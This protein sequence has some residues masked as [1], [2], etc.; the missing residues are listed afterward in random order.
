MKLALVSLCDS[1][2]VAPMGL[3]YIAGYLREYMDRLDIRI[4]DAAYEDPMAALECYQPDIVGVSA[5]T[6]QYSEAM[7]FCRE[8]K[9][10]MSVPIVLGGVHVST[11]PKSFTQEFD[12]GVI[13]EGEETMCELLRSFEQCGG[14]SKEALRSIPGLIFHE[15]GTLVR[16][17]PR[18]P[19]NPLDEIPMPDQSLLH[20]NYFI[21][22]REAIFPGKKLRYGRSLTIRGC[23]FQCS[24]C[25][26]TVFWNKVRFHSAERIALEVK[27]LVEDY[28]V[29]MIPIV[30]DLF[31]QSRKRLLQIVEELRKHGLLG[32]VK[33]AV[34]YRA[35]CIKD[36]LCEIL[37]EMGVV[38]VF[39][40]FESGNDRVLQSLKLGSINVAD[41]KRAILL[42]KK[43]GFIVHGSLMLGS[44]G[45]TIADMRDTLAFMDWMAQVDVDHIWFFVTTPFPETSFWEHCRK[46]NI[47]SDNMD[48]DI[49][50]MENI[51]K[52]LCLDDTVPMEEFRALLLD[53]EKKRKTL[54]PTPPIIERL[55][56]F[57]K[58]LKRVLLDPRRTIR[59]MAMR[60]IMR[61][62]AF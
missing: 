33:F 49:L 7:K 8:L 36:E 24:F 37:K 34:Q 31:T 20:K 1:K 60:Y 13:G 12:V 23:P 15:N 3:A 53:A 19:I 51:G 18:K 2:F 59:I 56:S 32:K 62:P 47:V 48:W 17:S 55:V 30:D 52:P 42:C 40:G 57:V 46:K 25:S 9:G 29:E 41:N 21:P 54:T 43:Y 6:M 14:L 35:N 28:G 58:R 27:R 50:S 26:T 45:E 11:C 44:P 38:T 16:T 4:I 39:F 22:R 5:T 61:R 10:R